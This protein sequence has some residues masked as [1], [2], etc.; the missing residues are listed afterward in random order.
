MQVATVFAALGGSEYGNGNVVASACVGHGVH[1][2]AE[3]PDKVNQKLERLASRRK[4]L[5]GVAQNPG[6]PADLRHHTVVARA[7]LRPVSRG[8]RG[9]I[10]VVPRACLGTAVAD[11]VRPG[12][13]GSQVVVA[14]EWP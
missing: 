7:V 13:E 2:L 8:R 11:I 12:G 1:R 14:Q 5:L 9:N 10:D 4:R 3:V 6:K